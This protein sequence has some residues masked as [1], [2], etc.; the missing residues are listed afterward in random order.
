MLQKGIEIVFGRPYREKRS[1]VAFYWMGIGVYLLLLLMAVLARFSFPDVLFP[2]IGYPLLFRFVYGVN[3]KLQ[4]SLAKRRMTPLIISAAFFAL[5][6]AIVQGIGA[7]GDGK[8]VSG[9]RASMTSKVSRNGNV[10]VSIGSL[11]GYYEVEKVQAVSGT[12]R[13]PYEAA[14]GSG[15]V[16]LQVRSGS[17]I[18]WEQHVSPAASGV[19]E[20]EPAADTSYSMGLQTA[21][22]ENIQLTF[23]TTD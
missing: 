6:V 7:A 16:T 11:S 15:E 19:I 18:I 12:I 5:T 8:G 17:G 4:G 2:L 22:A 10:T 3:A 21:N 14:V 9:Y 1:F 23:Q 13:I 20:F